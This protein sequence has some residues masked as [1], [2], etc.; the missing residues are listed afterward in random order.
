MFQFHI[1]GRI[2][3]RRA[4]KGFPELRIEAGEMQSPRN[5]FFG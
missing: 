4:H 1:S 2:I 3:D 5:F